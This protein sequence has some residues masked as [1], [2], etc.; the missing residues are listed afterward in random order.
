MKEGVRLIS[1][2]RR[3]EN[4][5]SAAVKGLPEWKRTPCRIRKVKVSPSSDTLKDSARPGISSALDLVSSMA[6][7][8]S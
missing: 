2:G 8:W 4:A 5:T 6:K 7:S 1:S 3:K